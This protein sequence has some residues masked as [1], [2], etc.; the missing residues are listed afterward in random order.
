MTDLLI[1]QTIDT[2]S[3]VFDITKSIL[4]IKGICTPEN[5]RLFFEPIMEKMLEFRNAHKELT[6]EVSLDYF[7]SGSSKCILDLFVAAS[8]DLRKT[9]TIKVKWFSEDEELKDAGI[10]FE[11]LSG[12]KF[13]YIDLI[14]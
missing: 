2:P 11:E 6:I 9:D 12:L 7:N 1:E 10:T 4:K 5:P 13:E 3:V 8:K 14:N